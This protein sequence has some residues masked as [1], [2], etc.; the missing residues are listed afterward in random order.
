MAG[1]VTPSSSGHKRNKH[2]S[3][4]QDS[5][6]NGKELDIEAEKARI[7]HLATTRNGVRVYKIVVIGDGG[8]GKSGMHSLLSK[9][10]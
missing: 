10:F 8:V 2:K 7:N 9:S 1:Q 6:K 5:N 4:K 3:N